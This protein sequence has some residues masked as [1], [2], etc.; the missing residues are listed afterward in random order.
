MVPA[1]GTGGLGGWFVRR[2]GLARFTTVALAFGLS[3]AALTG[4]RLLVA[5]VGLG[6][7][8][9]FLVGQFGL[10][11]RGTEKTPLSLI[12]VASVLLVGLLSGYLLGGVRVLTLSRSELAPHLGADVVARVTVT[13]F[14]RSSSSGRWQS[15]TAV[16][17]LIS[18]V[19]R[20]GV[21]PGVTPLP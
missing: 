1:K 7:T 16:V 19:Q 11:D 4:A 3:L 13:G 10:R 17:D 9:L 8:L 6:A 12:A 20:N 15:A 5:V 14:V 21:G 2:A 18:M